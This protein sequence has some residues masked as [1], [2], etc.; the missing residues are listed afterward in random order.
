[1]VGGGRG[2]MFWR[3]AWRRPTATCV[4]RTFQADHGVQ[5]PEP[6]ESITLYIKRDNNLVLGLL[7]VHNGR[8]TT[9]KK[10]KKAFSVG[11]LRIFFKK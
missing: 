6:A 9:I 11:I 5:V 3:S 10:C 7:N 8:D 4:A 2:A 1:M